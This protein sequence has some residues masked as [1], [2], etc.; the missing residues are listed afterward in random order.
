[1]TLLELIKGTFRDLGII[2]AGEIPGDDMVQ[3]ALQYLNSLVGHWNATMGLTVYAITEESLTLTIGAAS[4]TW[5]TGGNFNT[6]RPSTILGGYVNDGATDFPLEIIG[7]DRYASFSDKTSSGRPQYI[8]PLYTYPLATVYFYP[9][10]DSAYTFHAN[11]LKAFMEFASLTASLGLPREYERVLRSNL[12]VEIAPQYEK[13][14]SPVI[15]SIAASS[16]R[17]LRNK[18]AASRVDTVP[19][20]PWGSGSGSRGTFNS[21]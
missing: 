4:R 5:G 16:L 6:A 11:S 14:P 20:D 8:Y 17:A 1:M 10:P 15:A 21:F 9:T 12:A 3:D 2:A 13:V 19:T 7:P 18:V